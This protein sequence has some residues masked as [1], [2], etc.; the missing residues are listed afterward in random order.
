MRLSA[1][2]TMLVGVSSFAQVT[3]SSVTV[4]VSRDLNLQ[5]DQ[6]TFSVVVTTPSSATR[7]DAVSA[8]QGSGIT[9]ANFTSLSTTQDYSTG[10]TNPPTLLQWG[11][12]ETVALSTIKSAI[13]QLGTV[14]SNI[15]QK[16]NG[17]SMTFSLTGMGVSSQAQQTQPCP[18]DALISDG[19]AQ[20]MKL[21]SVAQMNLVS[22]LSISAPSFTSGSC[23]LTIKFNA[24]SF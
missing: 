23:T 14:Q 3:S 22:I 4:T 19:R 5:P 13:S 1:F 21:A 17:F 10:V 8:L 7:D 24:F 18:V 16:K 9:A 20:A 15:V 6:A 11:F 12:S 2:A